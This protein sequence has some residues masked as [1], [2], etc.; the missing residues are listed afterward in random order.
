MTALFASRCGVRTHA[1]EIHIFLSRGRVVYHT[2]MPII[3]PAPARSWACPWRPRR[4]LP[5]A[6]GCGTVTKVGR[7]RTWMSPP[8]P[9]YWRGHTGAAADPPHGHD[10][11]WAHAGGGTPPL[12]PVVPP[13]A[14]VSLRTPAV[15]ACPAR[16]GGWWSPLPFPASAP[17]PKGMLTASPPRPSFPPLLTPRWAPRWVSIK[18]PTPPRV[19]YN[20]PA[21]T[22]PPQV[23]VP[24][25]LSLAP[26]VAAA[27]HRQPPSR[28]RVAAAAVT[29]TGAP[30]RLLVC[31]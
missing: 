15:P 11:W 19:A 9:T 23:S 24:P 26:V 4:W 30:L 8:P 25:P 16:N 21:L 10:D 1:H 27:R 6:G 28:S 18:G 3:N 29:A 31:P 7:T 22:P 17:L 5:H 2:A 20:L 14:A 12:L 13:A